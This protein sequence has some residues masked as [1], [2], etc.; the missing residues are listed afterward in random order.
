MTASFHRLRFFAQQVELPDV[1]VRSIQHRQHGEE[2]GL[3]NAS[4]QVVHLGEFGARFFVDGNV[5]AVFTHQQ[6]SFRAERELGMKPN[7]AKQIRDDRT[8]EAV[9]Q[10]AQIP[11]GR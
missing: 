4:L 2:S 11:A 10:R 7:V 8:L 9:F 6:H 3:A 5:E 1:L